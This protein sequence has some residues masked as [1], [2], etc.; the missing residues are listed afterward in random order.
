MKINS[1]DEW[2]PLKEVIVGSPLNYSNDI[3]LSFKLFFNESTHNSRFCYLPSYEKSSSDK[4]SKSSAENGST[5]NN[6]PKQYLE[7]LTEDVDGLVDTLKKLSVKVHRPTP[8]NKGIHCKTPYWDATC[9]PAL[10]VRDQAIIIGDEIIETPPQVR[11]RYFENDLLKPI[12]YDYFNNGSKWIT[13][14]KAMMTDNSFDLS[15]VR[16]QVQL[17]FQDVISE[18]NPYEI[19]PSE[20]DVGHEIMIDGAQCVRF[21]KDIIVNV[22]NKNHELGLNWLERHLEDKFK[23]H[24]I[25]RMANN[26]I[27]SVI[28]PLRPGL[29]LLRSP[30]FLEFLPEPLKKWDIIYPP[31][32][33]KNNFPTYEQDSLILASQY[34]D[35][36]VLSI[37]ESTVIVNSLF[38]ELIAKLEKYKITPVPVRHR[39]RRLF[40]GGFHCFTL[41]TVREGE[42]EDYFS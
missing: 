39:H 9:I 31:E 4:Q 25:Y 16:D 35:L 21:G 30:K 15:Y 11:A 41:D 13:M 7:E 24:R 10:N 34:I 2:S 22:A 42:I 12:F 17:Q 26:H 27:D 18:E 28:L 29:L 40:G 20:F 1:Y 8:L 33:K 23:L 37:D 19:K 14:P 6:I 32:P 5:N 38:P 3:D 36:N